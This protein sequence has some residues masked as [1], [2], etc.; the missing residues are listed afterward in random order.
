MF[1]PDSVT[2]T[3][4]APTSEVEAALGEALDWQLSKL[5]GSRAAASPVQ[6]LVTLEVQ[7]DTLDLDL[8]TKEDYELRVRCHEDSASKSSIRRFVITEKFLLGPSPG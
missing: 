3:I 2:R 4:A 1:S 7:S 8:D 6:S 5:T